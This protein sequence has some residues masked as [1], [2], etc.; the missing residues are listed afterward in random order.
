MI[1]IKEDLDFGF[2]SEDDFLIVLKNKH[3][4]CIVDK[5]SSKWSSFDFKVKSAGTIIKEYELKT[6]RVN[7]GIF[8]TL[9]FGKSKWDYALKK[10]SQGVELEVVWKLNDCV[11][12]WVIDPTKKN[13]YYIGVGQNV[14]RGEKQKECIHV[15]CEYMNKWI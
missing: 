5:F 7:Y 10:H 8:P 6:R 2:A 13:E 12:S 11:V 14:R 15:K 1:S 4:R 3:D 9:I